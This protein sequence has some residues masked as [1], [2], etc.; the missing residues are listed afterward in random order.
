ME[1][2]KIEVGGKVK[3]KKRLVSVE[4]SAEEFKSIFREEMREF[5]EHVDRVKIQYRAV[6]DLKEGLLPG[7]VML[8]MDFAEDYRSQNADEIQNAYFGAG[9][10]TILP[11]VAYYR[12][13]ASEELSVQSFAVISDEKGHDAG[14]VY[15][16]LKKFL[17]VVRE[18]VL[19]VCQVFYWTDS[20]TSQ[21]TN[22]SIFQIVS[23]HESEFKSKANWNYFEAGHGKGPCK[24]G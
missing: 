20:P 9:N 4:V 22:K 1:K 14:A 2:V 8:Q 12:A 5:R 21:F 13:D 17:P 19:D 24:G 23:A 11:V 10:V 18:V 15:G 7:Q 16:F 6:K 3:D